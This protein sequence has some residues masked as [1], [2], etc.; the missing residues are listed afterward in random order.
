MST[1]CKGNPVTGPGGPIGWVEVSL[2][3]FLTTALEGGVWSA[4]RPGR[5]YHRERPGTHCTGG[6]VG[7]GAGLDRCGKSRPTRIR[8]PNLPARSESPYRLRYP[9]LPTQCSTG[10]YFCNT[11]FVSPINDKHDT[12]AKGIAKNHFKNILNFSIL[13][14]SKDNALSYIPS[15][16]S[17]T[18]PLYYRSTWWAEQFISLGK[19]RFR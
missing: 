18:S 8:S 11:R 1:Q 9:R 6:W 14:L 3:F 4:S 12:G 19:P 10:N 2:N 15:S 5:L 7:P 13:K 16:A 17:H